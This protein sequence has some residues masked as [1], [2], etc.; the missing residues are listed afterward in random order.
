[1]YNY[2]HEEPLERLMF[3]NEAAE[4]IWVKKEAQKELVGLSK[5]LKTTYNICFPS[6]ESTDVG[7]FFLAVLQGN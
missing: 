1:M 2:L 6:G 5:R 7:Q 3:L 4:F